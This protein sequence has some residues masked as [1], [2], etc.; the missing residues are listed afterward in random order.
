MMLSEFSTTTHGKWILAGEHAVIRGYPAIIVPILDKTLNLTYKNTLDEDFKV[1]SNIK[2]TEVVAFDALFTNVL[3]HGFRLL[4]KAN[5]KLSGHFHIE[6]TLPIGVGLGASAALCVA[7]ARW[8]AAIEL[9]SNSE[10]SNFSQQLEHLFHGKS[11][12][13]DIAGVSTDS[14]I[15]YK[16]Q[17]ITPFS[18]TW[19]PNWRLSSC[20]TIGKTSKCIEKVQE[21][22]QRDP[23]LAKDIDIQMSQSVENA[24]IALEN[25]TTNAI[26][27]LA[28]AI[29]K[30]GNCFQQWGLIPFELQQHIEELKTNG[31]LAVKPT[32]SGGGGYVISLWN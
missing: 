22:W 10:I 28:T 1:T 15:Y 6:S 4:S 25:T 3:E 12:G 30:A 26:N 13:V 23:V 29:N 24:K 31:A 9:I 7:I 27:L 14:F 19:S 16:A 11:S 5:F 17:T 32:G 8:F 18:P 2:E 20:N 21:L